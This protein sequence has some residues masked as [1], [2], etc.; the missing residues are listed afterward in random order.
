MMNLAEIRSLVGATQDW[1]PESLLYQEYLDTLINI[2]HKEVWERHGWVFAHRN[3]FLEIHPDIV[4][5]SAGASATSVNALVTNGSRTVQF[6][7]PVPGLS[8]GFADEPQP[9]GA[10]TSGLEAVADTWSGQL[11]EHGGREYEILNVL[12]FT[13]VVLKEP[14]R[15]TSGSTDVTNAWT[16]KHK[17]YR[18]PADCV[19]LLTVGRYSSPV[20]GVSNQ[21]QAQLIPIITSVQPSYQDRTAT[22]AS[23]IYYANPLVIPPG[24]KLSAEATNSADTSNLPDGFY[25]ELAWTYGL[26]GDYGPLSETLAVGPLNAGGGGY[27]TL[28]CTF[29]D[30]RSQALETPS[31]AEL[32]KPWP[33]RNEGLYKLL[34]HN[35]NIDTSTGDRLGN[36]VWLPVILNDGTNKEWKQVNAFSD[37]S[38]VTL[39]TPGQFATYGQRYLPHVTERIQP[40]PRITTPDITYSGV[41]IDDV[42]LPFVPFKRLI[43]QYLCKPPLLSWDEDTSPIP[44]EFHQVIV[45][46]V[47][48]MACIKQ[49]RPDLASYFAEKFEREVLG[50]ERRYLLFTSK[51]NQ[52]A[53]WGS[54]GD[55]RDYNFFSGQQVAWS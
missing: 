20:P 31:R 30:K 4:G 41:S 40:W 7:S 49:K 47:L 11:F 48:E 2:A 15:L 33:I 12:D 45:Y 38:T 10:Y 6:S 53:Q 52:T 9:S 32:L 44:P 36:P 27:N 29:L 13:T 26:D 14:A 23:H 37:V 51:N 55:I 17:Y 18:L 21:Y 28:T 39:T 54:S 8:A 5:S 50:L 25:T 43:I 24:E 35:A 19:K 1:L 34:W 46:K 3:A 42:L 16:I 22:M